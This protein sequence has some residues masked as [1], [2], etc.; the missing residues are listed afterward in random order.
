MATEENVTKMFETVCAAI[1][2]AKSLQ[3]LIHLSF[4]KDFVL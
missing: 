2:E 1:K 4:C 3:S